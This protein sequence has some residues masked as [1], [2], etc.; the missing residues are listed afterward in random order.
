MGHRE[1]GDGVGALRASPAPVAIPPGLA[2]VSLRAGTS[3][4][5]EAGPGA[6]PRLRRKSSRR[7]PPTSSPPSRSTRS[8]TTCSPRT[9]LT[10]ETSQRRQL[11]AVGPIP[12][13]PVTRGRHAPGERRAPGGAGSPPR[14][15]SRRGKLALRP[16][17]R[18]PARAY[19]QTRLVGNIRCLQGAPVS[20]KGFSADSKWCYVLRLA[21]RR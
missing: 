4:D 5:R 16:P 2:K 20:R 6:L 9:R 19:H 17:P 18:S 15:R 10:R 11:T 7:L 13:S 21:G 3:G 14:L 12:E 1:L 8:P